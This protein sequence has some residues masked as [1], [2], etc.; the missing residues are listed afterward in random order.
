ML[1]DFDASILS[2]T[3]PNFHNT[4]KRTDA[5]NKAM[6]DNLAGRK[7]EILDVY[8]GYIKYADDCA[9]ITQQLQNGGIPTRVT[10]NDTKL[11]NVLFDKHTGDGLCVIDLDTVMPGSLLFDYGDSLRFGASTAEE[12]EAFALA[13]EEAAIDAREN[14]FAAEKLDDDDNDEDTASDDDGDDD[15]DDNDGEYK[16]MFS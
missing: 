8:E 6:D 15:D 10:H 14:A 16:P 2:E 12:D 13:Q 5:L 4:P 3:I 7:D 9:I 1:S 11:N